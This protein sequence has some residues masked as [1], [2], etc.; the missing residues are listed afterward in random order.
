MVFPSCCCYPTRLTNGS[1][2]PSGAE[3]QPFAGVEARFDEFTRRSS[4]NFRLKTMDEDRELLRYYRDAWLEFDLCVQRLQAA[5]ADGSPDSL[6][7]LFLKVEVARLRY[8]SARDRLVSRMLAAENLAAETD[9][10]HAR[11]RGSAQLL[12][13]FG[14]RPGD[15]AE[16]DWL[17]A[18]ALVRQAAA[19]Q[20]H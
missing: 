15:S 12:W 3:N 20:T 13:E 4:A 5:A 6:K 18:E 1:L 16:K 10:D 11:I 14:G 7:P 17:C 2:C 19:S 8:S 9:S